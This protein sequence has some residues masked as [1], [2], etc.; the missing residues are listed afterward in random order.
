MILAII[1]GILAVLSLISAIILFYEVKH[2]PLIEDDDYMPKEEEVVKYCETFCQHCKFFDG[3]AMCLQENNF[4]VLT[5]H[6]VDLCK[7]DSFF[8]VK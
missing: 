2:A 1:L 5:N 3:T 4:G 8:E 7:K 6:L